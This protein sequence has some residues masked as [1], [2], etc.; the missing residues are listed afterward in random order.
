MRRRDVLTLAAGTAALA[1]PRL[2]TALRPQT[3]RFVPVN[4]LTLLD[5]SFAGLP[6]T[7]SHAYLVFDTLYGLDE[8]FTARPQMLDGHLVENAGTSRDLRLREGLRFHDG[9]PVLARDAVASIQRC[10]IREGF[11]QALMATTGELSAPDDSTIRFRLK[12]PFPHLPEALAGLATITPVIM[13]EHLANSDP[14]QPVSDM[15]GS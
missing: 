14:A 15:V 6:H 13:P 7:R 11:L 9:T 1:A 8:T 3:L 4:A 2:A 12:Y 5:L 10:A